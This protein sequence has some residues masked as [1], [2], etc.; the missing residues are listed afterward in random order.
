[1]SSRP[2]LSALLLPWY[3]QH[4]RPLLWRQST[5]PYPVWL[6][7]IMLQQT[8]VVTATPYYARFLDKWP[9]IESLAA[10]SEDEVLSAWAGLGYYTRARNLH[11]CAKVVCAD[12]NGQFPD[13]EAGLMGLPGIG[14]YTAA[15]VAAIAFDRRANVVD[16][17][18]ERVMARLHTLAEPMPQSK[19]ALK[20][21]AAQHLPEKRCGDYAQAL[22]DLG[23][24]ICTP[25]SP[26]CGACPVATLCKAVKEG[27][28]ERYPVRSAKKA[29]P[30]RST[31]AYALFDAEGRICLKKRPET[32]LFANM[33]EI[34]S[35][36]WQNGDKTPPFTAAIDWHDA[37][38]QI[39]HVFTHFTL[40][41]AVKVGYLAP[42]AHKPDG[43]WVSPKE[44]HDMA[45]PSLMKKILAVALRHSAKRAK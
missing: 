20:A 27:T 11:K 37:P 35:T 38:E 18:V 42:R 32:G 30:E 13:T 28:P 1:M 24:T 2:S 29:R 10:A 43:I 23:A 45:L 36:D 15:A 39:K 12:Y 25:R 34:P 17:N 14:P 8:T 7:E 21:L 22:M 31:T 5:L 41:A 40:F 3:D 6:A 9:T 19:P 16:G 44:A 33:M 4:K 26:A